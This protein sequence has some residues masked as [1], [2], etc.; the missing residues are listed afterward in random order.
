MTLTPRGFT[1]IGLAVGAAGNAIMWAA[2]AYF[3]FYP[4]PNLLIL[5]AGALIVAFVRR[6]W[7]PAVG[8]LLGIV[9]IVAFAIIS[10][11]N[12]AGTGHLTGTAGV[13]GVIGTVLH[14]AGSAVGA[15]GGL[16]AAVFERRAEPAAESGPL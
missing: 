2:G 15:G 13:V 7:A 5:V 1:V 9:I 4:P 11:I 3:P 6:S 10:L 16:A 8:A 12:G 14:L